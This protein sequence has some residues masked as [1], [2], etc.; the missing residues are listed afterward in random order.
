MTDARKEWI[1]KAHAVPI[2]DELDRCGIKLRG[3]KER[4][5][6]CPVC[7]GTDRFSIN[8]DKQVFNCRGCGIG[9]DVIALV[10]HIDGVDIAT[11]CTTL[12]GDPPPDRGPVRG[13]NDMRS[14]GTQR[15]SSRRPAKPPPTPKQSE[16]RIDWDHPQAEFVYTNEDGTA[17]LYKNVRYPKLNLDGTVQLSAKGK[18][19][20]TFRQYRREGN[21]WIERLDG[22]VK[23]VPYRLPEML[24]AIKGNQAVFIVEGEAK[25][26]RLRTLGCAATS[27]ASGPIAGANAHYFRGVDVYL[28]PD[29]DEQGEKRI[30]AVGAALVRDALRV[31]VIRLPR[32]SPGEDII[33]WLDRQG[34]TTE[35][36]LKLY[37]AAPLWRPTQGGAPGNGHAP[38]D[39]A[40]FDDE[41]PQQPPTPVVLK[42]TR[43][44]IVTMKPIEWLWPDRFALGKLGII[45]GLPDEGK[46][47]ILCDMAAR[48][49]RGDP[50]P[51]NEGMAPQGNIIHLSAEDDPADTIVPRLAAAGA[52]LSR[53]E[54]VT[55]VKEKD[56][57]RMFSLVTDLELLRRKIIEVGN[58]K[59]I[60]IDPIS[61]YLG[62]GKVDSFRTTDVRAVL[63]PLVD[64]AAEMKVS[65]IGIMH[66][67]KKIDVTNA[68]LR[69]S[70]SLAFG[71]TA[72]HVYAAVDDAENQRKLFVR[73]KNNLASSDK[74]ALA[75]NFEQKQVAPDIWAP[76]IVW[77]PEHVDVTANEAMQAVNGNKSPA[78]RDDAKTFLEDFLEGGPMLQ[79]EVMEA[80]KASMISDKTLRRAKGDLGVKSRK[81]HPD[82]KWRWELPPK[83]KSWND[84]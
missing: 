56:K 81:N 49:T 41:L 84:D 10:M 6:P 17:V 14:N 74:Q 2:Q 19:D 46:G 9:G 15:Q 62:V 44:D 73:G 39:D 4:A 24:E 43:A 82:G 30:D 59:M 38:F 67:N 25:A 54:L 58:V 16:F 51:C 50:W 48:T 80:A 61:A 11:A 21:A 71:A 28:M 34:G 64:L 22:K 5:G 36:L 3:R 57:E 32:L 31:F 75:Y 8:T 23:Q 55:M 69:I 83:A 37:E 40:P 60:Q 27:I 45:A 12:V 72:R 18:P 65:I 66:F 77:Q 52:D 70:D 35:E 20:K 76:H 53:I 63:A 33:D 42:S 7:G 78:A 79:T 47:Q 26:D 29:N 1:A 68:L 13:A